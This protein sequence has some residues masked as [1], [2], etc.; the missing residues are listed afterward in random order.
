M[1]LH[2]KEELF[3]ALLDEAFEA[4]FADLQTRLAKLPTDE[5]TTRI[6]ILIFTRML[7]E[8]LEQHSLLLRLLP[9]L[10]TVLEHNIP[11]AAALAY[12]QHLG[13]NLVQTG[14]Q[15]E[16]CFP[17]LRE[18]QGVELLLSAYAGLIGLQS[19]CA[20]SDVV[21]EVLERPE[22]ALLVVDGPTALRQM[23]SRLLLGLWCEN[24]RTK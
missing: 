8:S 6:H 19:M 10:H 18:G 15:M 7:S 13:T 4:W 12:K 14:A 23:V 1:T 24:E 5:P 2:S 21:R 9:I 20:P 11:L 3:L 22:M 16:A 17:F